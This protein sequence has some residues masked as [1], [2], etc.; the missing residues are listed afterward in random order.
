MDAKP[1]ER[2]NHNS[3][4]KKNFLIQTKSQNQFQ[5]LNNIILPLE[6]FLRHSKMPKSNFISTDTVAGLMG[7]Q[8]SFEILFMLGFH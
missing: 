6:K 1:T 2:N 8:R 5:E 7:Q 3:Q 4:Q